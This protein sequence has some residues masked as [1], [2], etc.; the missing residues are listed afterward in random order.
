M[1]MPAGAT[2]TDHRTRRH[3]AKTDGVLTMNQTDQTDQTG[4]RQQREPS[5]PRR[6]LQI[7][8]IT[9]LMLTSAITM[10]L[11]GSIAAAAA[12]SDGT[13]YATALHEG[14]EDDAHRSQN[15]D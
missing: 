8:L 15:S 11:T 9:A 3:G 6:P 12:A 14:E 13:G 2:E 5:P 7:G 1:E 4:Q 10:W